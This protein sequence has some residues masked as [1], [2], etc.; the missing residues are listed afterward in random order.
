MTRRCFGRMF[1][2]R[3]SPQVE[4][5]FSYC[6]ALAAEKYGIQVH[7]L[8]VLSNHWHGLVTDP[9]GTLPEFLRWLH[10][11]VAKA[12]NVHLRRGESLWAPGSYSAVHLGDE[13]AVLDKLVYVIT[14]GVAAG[15]V[16]TPGEWPGLHTLAEDVGTRVV[17]AARPDFFF[18]QP[19]ADAD[20]E[21]DRADD[22][23]RARRRRRE[24]ARD[25]LPDRA[26]LAITV[27]PAFA[28]MPPEEFRALLGRAVDE[29]VAQLHRQ[30][31]GRPWLGAEAV[32]RQEP[33][34]SPGSTAPDGSLNPR[35]ACRDKWRRIELL[36][37]QVEFWHE[38]RQALARYRQGDRDA[39]FPE[40][41][42]WLRVQFG[43]TCRAAA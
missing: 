26:R 34:A 36:E 38:Y 41:T 4:A 3:P 14:N 25:P 35:I 9:R 13:A 10:C 39:V 20:E 42:Y 30:R 11:N 24:P 8:I 27:P 23:A 40:G 22:S 43:V 7:A 37:T 33:N 1:L 29:R 16:P 21:A 5:V 17:D 6:L 18:R 19:A 2:L 32:L 12:L 15:L 31:A 28:A